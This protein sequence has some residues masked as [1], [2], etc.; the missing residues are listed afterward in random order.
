MM[1]F[2]AGLNEKSVIDRAYERLRILSEQDEWKNA[3]LDY[4][5]VLSWF[6]GLFGDRKT[7]VAEIIANVLEP[8]MAVSILKDYINDDT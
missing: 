6:S 8:D 2:L 5:L 1:P 3:R 7:S 4:K